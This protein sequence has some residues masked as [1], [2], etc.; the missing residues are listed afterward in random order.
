MYRLFIWGGTY[1]FGWGEIHNE[2]HLEGKIVN[3]GIANFKD[4]TG[5][6]SKFQF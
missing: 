2:G 6:S 3:K 4:I 1:G 5:K